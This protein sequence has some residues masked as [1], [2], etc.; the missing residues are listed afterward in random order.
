MTQNDDFTIEIARFM[1][2]ISVLLT[3]IEKI[4]SEHPDQKD[5]MDL[6][7]MI[8][9]VKTLVDGVLKKAGT[10]FTDVSNNQNKLEQDL[11]YIK[12]TLSEFSE[13]FAYYDAKEFKKNMDKLETIMNS[14]SGENSDLS[15]V[16]TFCS[17]LKAELDKQRIIWETNKVSSD[18][19]KEVV[20][21]SKRMNMVSDWFS[22]WKKAIVLLVGGGMLFLVYMDKLIDLFNYIEVLSK[23][24]TP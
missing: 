4:L 3:N 5:Y 10:G 21:M 22:G 9:E 7:N 12:R 1:G 2:S 17:I 18:D 8:V 14:T 24:I 13:K 15:I 20:I 19:I 11:S 6:R 23:G 16:A